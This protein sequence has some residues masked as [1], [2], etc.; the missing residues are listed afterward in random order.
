MFPL[1]G[2]PVKITSNIVKTG[3]PTVCKNLLLHKSAMAIAWQK[4]TVIDRARAVPA[5]ILGDII[6]AQSLYGLNVIRSDH[7]VVINSKA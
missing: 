7:F 2:K 6:V 4:E 1:L 3:T 5:L